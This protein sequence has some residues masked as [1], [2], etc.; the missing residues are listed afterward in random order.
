M[1]ACLCSQYSK[2]SKFVDGGVGIRGCYLNYYEIVSEHLP[3]SISEDNYF[4][5]P[6]LFLRPGDSNIS[7]Q[8]Q[9]GYSLG[10]GVYVKSYPMIAGVGLN[11]R[12]K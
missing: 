5:E 6:V 8:A 10:S 3:Y 9:L 7:F 4:I 12:L 11:I 2:Y 1:C